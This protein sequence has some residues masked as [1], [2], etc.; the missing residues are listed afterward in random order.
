ML[1]LTA[2][3]YRLWFIDIPVD[4]VIVLWFVW[5]M[6]IDICLRPCFLTSAF[7]RSSN[8]HRQRPHLLFYL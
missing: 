4:I 5:F 8:I 3:R 6:F 2:R 7:L 1:V